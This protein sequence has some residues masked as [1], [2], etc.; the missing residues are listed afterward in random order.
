VGIQAMGDDDKPEEEA[1]KS[2]AQ[3]Q[4]EGDAN[5]GPTVEQPSP[6]DNLT[7]NDD[8]SK[9]DTE[10]HSVAGASNNTTPQQGAD[11][12][13]VRNDAK[14]AFARFDT[15]GKTNADGSQEGDGILDLDE[16]KKAIR[17]LR[18]ERFAR[19]TGLDAK[20]YA[21]ISDATLEKYF[22]H[23]DYDNSGELDIDEFLQCYEHLDEWAKDPDTGT[24]MLAQGM[25]QLLSHTIPGAQNATNAGTYVGNALETTKKKEVGES[26]GLLKNQKSSSDSSKCGIICV[27]ITMGLFFIVTAL[28]II[29]PTILLWMGVASG[30]SCNQPLDS[31]VFTMAIIATFQVFT[32]GCVLCL[33]LPTLWALAY[34]LVLP[35][36]LLKGQNQTEQKQMLEAKKDAQLAIINSK[37]QENYAQ[38]LPEKGSLMQNVVFNA[39]SCSSCLENFVFIWGL[40]TFCNAG[41]FSSDTTDCSQNASTLFTVTYAFFLVRFALI[42]LMCCGGCC[43]FCFSGYLAVNTVAV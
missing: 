12:I 33:Y 43:T 3:T 14:R 32:L 25:L 7:T 30:Q 4:G 13:A 27:L 28:L 40:V 38:N 37:M 23:F 36:S 26:S 11:S 22:Y 15:G 29:G 17:T 18:E 1:G 16:F 39:I 5:P 2:L 9:D 6:E 42:A 20:R 34:P 10:L 35:S 21:I 8:T 41:G 19:D 24:N 31:W